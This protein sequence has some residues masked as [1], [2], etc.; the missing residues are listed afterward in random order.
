MSGGERV[1]PVELVDEIERAGIG[2]RVV[3]DDE[4]AGQPVDEVR[5]RG[6]DLRGLAR[7]SPA[8]CACSHRIFG[9][10]DCEVSALPQRSRSASSPIAAVSSSIS[11]GRARIDAVEDARSSAARRRRRPAACTGRW[12]SSPTA[13]MSAGATPLSASSLRLMK[14]KSSHQSSRGRCSA[15]PGCGTSILCGLAARGDDRG[16]SPSTSTPFDSKVPMSM[17]R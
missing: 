10:T 3:V 16:P 13:R 5:G 6:Q 12:R 17:P 14:V 9:P 11:V 8:G 4:G 2:R 15:Q 1:A 7:R